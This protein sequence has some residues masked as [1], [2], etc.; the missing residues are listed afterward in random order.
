MGR[1]REIN[2]EEIEI[3]QPFD[4][5]PVEKKWMFNPPSRIS[6]TLGVPLLIGKVPII[7]LLEANEVRA[8]ELVK[9]PVYIS[10]AYG[11]WCVGKA[12]S[13]PKYSLFFI[14]TGCEVFQGSLGECNRRMMLLPPFPTNV[15]IDPPLTV[16]EWM[17]TAEIMRRSPQWAQIEQVLFGVKDFS[18]EEIA[19]IVS[20]GN[21]KQKKRKVK[22]ENG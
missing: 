18:D 16:D 7:F 10:Y 9:F 3:I 21:H 15:P 11:W 2:L 14:P 4:N 19:R 20:A 22:N 12:R 17:T 8:G 6:S 13:R 1:K 5:I